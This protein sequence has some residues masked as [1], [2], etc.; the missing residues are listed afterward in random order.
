M[1]GRFAR[2]A[3]SRSSALRHQG[4]CCIRLDA[5]HSHAHIT[6]CMLHACGRFCCASLSA[7]SAAIAYP[8][9]RG[10]EKER[11]VRCGRQLAAAGMAWR[12]GRRRWQ[13]T[14]KT[15]RTGDNARGLNADAVESHICI[16]RAGG[17]YG[18]TAGRAC[19]FRCA[20][21]VGW[22]LHCCAGGL[23]R[24]TRSA[25]LKAAALLV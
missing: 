19:R 13:S 9:R 5:A 6:L 10:Q 1:D 4:R 22:R 23:V 16:G 11:G 14:Q 18:A 17:R 3:I 8:R 15:Y 2:V 12:G 25:C 24:V 21:G 7:S 20:I